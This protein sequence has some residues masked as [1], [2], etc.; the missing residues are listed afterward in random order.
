M[1]TNPTVGESQLQRIIRDL[2][3]AVAELTREYNESGEPITDDSSNLHK[4]SYKLE[5][6]LQ[7]DQKEKSTLLG[8]R[9]DYWDYFTDCLA[10]V[11]G[12]NDGIRFV[13]SISEL[14][15]SVGKG[16]AFLRYCLVHQRL[17]DTL[18][19]CLMN[20][21]V[22]S[23]WYYSRSPL[24]KAHL[25]VDIIN[26]LYE[27]NNVQFDVASRGHD[28]DSAWPTFARRTLG[29]SNSSCYLWKP[30]SRSSSINSLA[31]SY[32][33]AQEFLSSPD[34]ERSGLSG[35]GVLESSA[36]A[37]DTSAMEE[38]RLELDRCELRE[39]E[40]LIQV[41]QL[42]SEAAELR[43]VMLEL[44]R[45][46]DVALEAQARQVER[47]RGLAVQM[48]AEG[49]ALEARRKQL[50]ASERHAQE[51][52]SQLDAA[53]EEKGE[54]AA[55]ALDSAHKIHVL[56]DQL[57]EEQRGH[58]QAQQEAEKSHKE[59][60]CLR[61][62]LRVNA[63]LLKEA[64]GEREALQEQITLL[65]EQ[66]GFLQEEQEEAGRAVREE[67]EALRTEAK[68]LQECLSVMEVE[69]DGLKGCVAEL[70]ADG[71]DHGRRAEE[72]RSQC[73]SLMG[74]NEGLLETVRRSEESQRELAEGAAAA[75]ER[76]AQLQEEARGYEQRLH[77]LSAQ[78]QATE[79][80]VKHLEEE[81]LALQGSS[82]KA[83][84]ERQEAQAHVRQLEQQLVSSS[85]EIG[86]LHEQVK[87][88]AADVERAH[89]ELGACKEEQEA[90]LQQL[91]QGE[92]LSGE[93]EGAR[94]EVQGLKAQ[95]ERLALEHTETSE[96]LHRANTETAEL[97]FTL[98]R[99]K[100]ER[101]E[102]CQRRKEVEEEA[103]SEAGRLNASVDLLQQEN[104][105]LREELN[106]AER[107]SEALLE[108]QDKLEKA[109]A[110]V[111]RQQDTG[112]Q[113]VQAFRFQMSSEHMSLRSQI[114]ALQGELETTRGQMKA[115]EDKT[116]N[117]ELKL[118]ELEGANEEYSQLIEE[119]DA[120]ITKAEKE[121]RESQTAISK[122]EEKLNS[123][124]K[125]LSSLQ[126]VRIE[127]SQRLEEVQSEAQRQWFSMGEQMQELAFTKNHLE[128]RLIELLKDKDALWQKS[129]AL[130]FEQKVRAEERWVTDKEAPHCLD[131]QGQFTW[132]LR[133]HHCRLCGRI[134]CY[135]CSNNYVMTKHSSKKERC[136]R[137]CYTQHNAVVER[138]T[139]AELHTEPPP[140]H[141]PPT[142]YIP[143]PRVT[144]IDPAVKQEEG[145]YD[146]I[147]EEEVN[148]IYDDSPSQATASSQDG[149]VEGLAGASTDMCGEGREESGVS[150]EEQEEMRAPLQ[151]AEINLLKS[152][153]LSELVS[154][155]LADICTF[156]DASR[157]LVVSA[158]GYSL[159]AISV[160]DSGASLGWLFSSQ[161]KS[162]AFSVLYRDQGHLPVEHSKVLI[163]LTRC[164][165]HNETIKGQLKV[166]NP[167][168]YTLIFDNSFSR[169]NSKKVLYH[170]T[171]ERAIIYDGSDCTQ[172]SSS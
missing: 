84:Q 65:R 115:E 164:N 154:L 46:L 18:Q 23:D 49:A 132:Y 157:E 143:T 147:T 67:H 138:F 167:G 172:G 170:L 98:C 9:K 110:Q 153:D 139:H 31:S 111:Q 108:V 134:F 105:A 95:L 7:F 64:Q 90:L 37:D 102:A 128:E 92:G 19:Q 77:T 6:L 117:L 135:Y 32:S 40:L 165:S 5:Y 107:L 74:L 85:Q 130:E 83:H 73:A 36:G 41:G 33:Q 141:I 136:C 62:E 63:E 50:E 24:L 29:L 166:R 11:K 121:L 106:Q 149:Q 8:N 86:R 54:W 30:P 45:Q 78:A 137:E 148:G 159:I 93:L 13:K 162:V 146:I 56:L 158:S 75:K 22:T 52:M 97:G 20:Q 55:G 10:K 43:G 61:E 1:A 25:S 145:A 140:P 131:C 3:D 91:R 160:A 34:L 39:K 71:R 82:E 150:C 152:G 168:I 101:E 14:K 144:V 47:E 120:Y 133:R 27:L 155:S 58:S 104:A 119:K 70:E 123:S 142:P 118:A 96:S 87:S 94:F 113:E 4:F 127:L 28:L 80:R 124:E 125:A 2:N 76:E 171:V 126:A 12:A 81:N 57:Q 48:E 16:R 116:S 89:M 26:H 42:G 15:T 79:A 44:Q 59:A 103:Q 100:S 112:R 161:P 17:A 21:R 151:D 72:Y 66:L 88:M 60:Q 169:F 163:P 51:L 122:L 53:L 69:R 38:L 129:D 68:A 114:Q 156:G 35:V 99:L 109:E